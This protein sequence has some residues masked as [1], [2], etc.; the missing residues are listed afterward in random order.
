MLKRIITRV[1]I[2]LMLL[3]II[4]LS[5]LLAQYI[6]L[7][8]ETNKPKFGYYLDKDY[9]ITNMDLK[10]HNRI[11][12]FFSVGKNKKDDV[13]K[14]IKFVS[15]NNMDNKE[16]KYLYLKILFNDK[17]YDVSMQDDYNE[18]IEG[19]SQG[20]EDYLLNINYNNES[21]FINSIIIKEI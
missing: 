20:K 17:E 21:G 10:N 3:T 19:I 7:Y 6:N 5:I 4:I 12:E 2:F 9:K 1:L 11:Y 18:L 16:N 8:R 13:I 14:L 15:S